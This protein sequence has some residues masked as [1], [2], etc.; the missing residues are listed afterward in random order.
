[1]IFLRVV[2]FLEKLAEG[3]R[4][5][6]DAFGNFAGGFD[7]LDRM[8]VSGLPVGSGVGDLAA[9]DFEVL[10]LQNRVREPVGFGQFHRGAVFEQERQH[11]K[12]TTE[13]QAE[14]AP[15]ILT[16]VHRPFA[17][18]ISSPQDQIG[19]RHEQYVTEKKWPFWK[20]GH[21]PFTHSNARCNGF[22]RHW[23]WKSAGARRG[24]PGTTT[25]SSPVCKIPKTP[26]P[27]PQSDVAFRPG[28]GNTCVTSAWWWRR[29]APAR[30]SPSRRG[31]R[32]I[33]AF[34][35]GRESE[36]RTADRVNFAPPRRRPR[37]R[38][39]QFQDFSRTRRRTRTNSASGGVSDF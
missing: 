20:F 17:M 8:F 36:V 1:M 33:F 16:G 24:Q 21:S 10:N 37:S 13:A 30:R 29:V 28:E 4:F 2:G 25:L 19:E 12:H 27:V 23:R 26:H 22:R 18:R 31:R 32:R 39:R 3:P 7:G 5:G 15:K 6:S 35:P 38:P 34:A 9:D 11:A 14:D